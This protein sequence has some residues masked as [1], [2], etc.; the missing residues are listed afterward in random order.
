MRKKGILEPDHGAVRSIQQ[1]IV[2]GSSKKVLLVSARFQA[3]AALKSRMA[4]FLWNGTWGRFGGDFL[5]MSGLDEGP[6]DDFWPI[7]GQG[8]A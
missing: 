8:N 4:F 3:L 7:I 2:S 1:E 6:F 5:H